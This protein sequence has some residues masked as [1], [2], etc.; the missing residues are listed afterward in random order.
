MKKIK[1]DPMKLSLKDTGIVF[2]EFLQ[3]LSRDMY[4]KAG[5]YRALEVMEQLLRK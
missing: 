1:K 5:E 4:Q 2:E 3:D